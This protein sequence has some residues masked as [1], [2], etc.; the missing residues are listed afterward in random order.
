MKAILLLSQLVI[1]QIPADVSEENFI[2][3]TI[4]TVSCVRS[5]EFDGVV[6]TTEG[7]S[8]GTAELKRIIVQAKDHGG[9]LACAEEVL[10]QIDGVKL[11]EVFPSLGLFLLNY[12]ISQTA[13]QPVEEPVK[14]KDDFW[15]CLAI[16]HCPPFEG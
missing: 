10:D 5:A 8:S 14:P 1:P 6:H 16:H 11:Q 7:S 3:K 12:E 9:A 15:S 13:K 2:L 4:E